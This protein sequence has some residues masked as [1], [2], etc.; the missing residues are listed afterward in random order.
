MQLLTGTGHLAPLEV[1]DQVSGYV[2]RFVDG[3]T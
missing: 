2:D 3:V 1:P